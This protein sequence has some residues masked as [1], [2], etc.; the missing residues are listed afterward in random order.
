MP[1]Q[2]DLVFHLNGETLTSLPFR[3]MRE[4]LLG[5]T[6]EDALQT[7]LANYPQI[8]PGKQIDSSNEEPPRFVL[9]RREMPVG[10]WS[11]DHLFV[12]QYGILTLVETKLF[13]NPESRREVVGQLMEYAANAI[14]AWGDGK[15]RVKAAEY[16][17]NQ[18]PP[19]EIGDVLKSEFGDE[20]DIEEFWYRTENNIKNGRMRLIV[21]TDELRPEIRRIIEYLNSEMQNAEVL[22]LELKCYGADGN[23]LVLVP[24]LV[25]QTQLTINKKT[26]TPPKIKWTPEQLRTHYSEYSDHDLSEKL[27]RILG[28]ALDKN[29]FAS[30]I[31]I[32]PYFA[33]TRKSGNRI[34]A[35]AYDGA[36]YAQINTRYFQN[37]EERNGFIQELIKLEL[38]DS[39][40][41]PDDVIEGRNLTKKLCGSLKS[42]SNPIGVT[43]SVTPPCYNSLKL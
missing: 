37:I 30:S 28:W 43:G 2:S 23:S 34:F 11:L 6:L 25:G 26:E 20:L 39:D 1:N 35:I 19:R 9:L 21:A 5:K 29:C 22:G 13:Q 40:L 36:I 3:S 27:L 4:G 33:L 41:N 31:S 18:T 24:H 8:L 17:S 7:L 38:I 42:S 10:G 15:V 32:K 14:E 12:D 16:W